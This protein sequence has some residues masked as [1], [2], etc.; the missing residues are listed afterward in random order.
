MDGPGSVDDRLSRVTRRPAGYRLEAYAS[1]RTSAGYLN[2]NTSGDTASTD[3]ANRG[4]GSTDTR[5]VP[6][7]IREHSIQ[8][9]SNCRDNI[10]GQKRRGR[11]DP[12]KHEFLPAI[13]LP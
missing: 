12:R 3:A 6:N 8:G 5:T 10:Q 1:L 9:R 11:E 13:C 7:N 2:T 4:D